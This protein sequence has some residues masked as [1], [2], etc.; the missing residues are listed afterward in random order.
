MC[1]NESTILGSI[2]NTIGRLYVIFTFTTHIFCI[3]TI[4][5][6]FATAN[7]RQFMIGS[8]SQQLY[9]E[10]EVPTIGSHTMSTSSGE[11]SEA[12]MC[13]CMSY[14][15]IYFSC[16]R[17]QARFIRAR[18]QKNLKNQKSNCHFRVRCRGY[19]LCEGFTIAF[20]VQKSS[21][22]VMETPCTKDENTPDPIYFKDAGT[23]TICGCYSTC[24][25][26]RSFFVLSNFY[27]LELHDETC[28][29]SANLR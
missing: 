13:I 22:P 5:K 3:S 16:S 27:R 18:D 2:V 20:E 11:Q 29:P 15:N 14:S 1:S 6:R 17:F 8:N 19:S 10:L 24:Y 26:F 28:V 12:H 25:R 21:V 4:P 23:L 7:M 9:V